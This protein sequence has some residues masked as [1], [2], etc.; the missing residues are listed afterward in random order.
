VKETTT[1]TTTEQSGKTPFAEAPL[2]FHS[3]GWLFVW[4]RLYNAFTANE[5]LKEQLL[6]LYGPTESSSLQRRSSYG[7]VALRR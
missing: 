6:A 4:Q 1:M 7:N 2:C 5:R 3:T